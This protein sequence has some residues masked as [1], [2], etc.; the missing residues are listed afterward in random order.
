[1]IHP[2][3]ESES[4]GFVNPP[5]ELSC[6][7]FCPCYLAIARRRCPDLRLKVAGRRIDEGYFKE[8]A[9]SIKLSGLEAVGCLR[10]GRV[11]RAVVQGELAAALPRLRGVRLSVDDR[12]VRPSVGRSDG[13]RRADREFEP[14]RDARDPG[15]GRPILRSTRCKRNGRRDCSH[16]PGARSGGG[17]E[18]ART[19]P[20]GAVLV[21]PI[22]ATDRGCPG[23]GRHERGVARHDMTARRSLNFA[24]PTFQGGVRPR[25][26]SRRTSS[27]GH[28]NASGERYVARTF[29]QLRHGAMK[30]LINALSARR[31]GIVT[32]MHHVT[33]ALVERGLD[34]VIAAPSNLRFENGHGRHIKFDVAE[35]RPLRRGIWEQVLWGGIVSRFGPKCFFLPPT[36]RFCD[37]QCRGSC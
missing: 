33:A 20:S 10:R 35:Y 9:E 11:P 7:E 8:V 27:P 32:Y 24:P 29:K 22:G 31:R 34:I 1:M 28:C 23:L 2:E 5:N 12:D 15:R 16:H 26:A 36:T 19:A 21:A 25:Q 30:I 6:P 18:R 3:N 37:A 14:N 4:N 17:A 13:E